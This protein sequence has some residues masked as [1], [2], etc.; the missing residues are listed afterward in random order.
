MER[1]KENLATDRL[2]QIRKELPYHYYGE[3]KKEFKTLHKGEP[4]PSRQTVYLTLQGKVKNIKVMSTLIGM[5][6]KRVEI[7]QKIDQ[8][9][10]HAQG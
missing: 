5:I 10:S 3:F 1:N 9:L 6:E 7:N 2:E 4:M 8:V